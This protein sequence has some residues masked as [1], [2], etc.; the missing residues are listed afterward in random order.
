MPRSPRLG[1][2]FLAALLCLSCNKISFDPPGEKA[3]SALQ[4]VSTKS[5]RIEMDVPAGWFAK[6]QNV[7]FDLQV[8]SGSEQMNTGVFEYPATDMAKDADPHEL[9]D[10]HVED[11]RSKRENFEVYA[12]EQ[13]VELPDKKLTTVVYTG[14]RGSGRYLYS[15][16]LVEFESEASVYPVILQVSF[17]SEWS[18]DKPVLEE[19]VQSIR[20]AEPTRAKADSEPE[21]A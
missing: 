19:I 13:V 18:E 6:D 11:M 17:P 14:E 8:M 10:F 7:Q 12:D 3:D 20:V 5:G 21:S 9:L 16:T 4:T 1:L 15:F 2:T